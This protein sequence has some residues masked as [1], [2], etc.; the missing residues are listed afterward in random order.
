MP[1]AS[2]PPAEQMTRRDKRRVAIFGAAALLIL[3]AIAV[4]AANRPG[5]YGAS[6]DGCITVTMPSTTGGALI[7]QCGAGAKATCRR[8]YASSD[9][10]SQLTRPQCRLAGLT[11]SRVAAAAG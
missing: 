2:L 9:K 11:P 3:A 7:H 10:V 5:S 8:A 6:R 1:F 4:W